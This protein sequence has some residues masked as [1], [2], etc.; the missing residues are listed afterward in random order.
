[1]KKYIG[2]DIIDAFL[3]QHTENVHRSISE[4]MERMREK[5]L[6]K[7]INE[8]PDVLPGE[9]N[10][11]IEDLLIKRSEESAAALHDYMDENGYEFEYH[12]PES[13]G[14]KYNPK[15]NVIDFG[16]NPDDYN[17]VVKQ[18]IYKG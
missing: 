12:I 9:M 3:Q 16:F 18:E 1:M 17:I 7:L 13:H 10:Q 11:L 4:A 5:K 2:Q 15:T 6:W 8:Y 14:P